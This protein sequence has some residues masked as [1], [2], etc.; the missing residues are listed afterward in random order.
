M[1]HHRRHPLSTGL[2]C[3]FAYHA[4]SDSVTSNSSRGT[5]VNGGL[6]TVGSR[7]ITRPRNEASS[8]GGIFFLAAPPLRTRIRADQGA[9]WLWR[10]S[11]GRRRVISF[12]PPAALCGCFLP[13]PGRERLKTS[14]LSVERGRI[15]EMATI[16]TSL[17]TCP[18][19]TEAGTV[20]HLENGG[21]TGKRSGVT[22]PERIPLFSTCHV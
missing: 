22:R 9:D 12:A 17:V 8:S 14:M 20:G 5:S 15:A 10:E 16:D 2:Y 7:P 11:V 19:S 3:H 1:S 18:S 21:E 13:I 6:C 4:G